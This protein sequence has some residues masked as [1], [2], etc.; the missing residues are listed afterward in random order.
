[1]NFL[2]RVVRLIDGLNERVGRFVAWLTTFLVL[3]VCFDVVTRYLLNES[4]VAV[5]ELE[6]HVF[7]VIF[8]LGAAYTLKEDGH[9]RVDVFYSHLTPKK[10]A[11]IDLVG[12]LIF[13]IPFAILVVTTSKAFVQM[14]W[15]VH[16]GSP[17]PGGLPARYLLK[18]VIPAGFVL[19][20]L[21]GIA[22]ALRSFLTLVG[23]PVDAE[24]VAAADAAGK[25]V[26]H[27]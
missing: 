15:A 10:K 23:R 19:V 16:E 17:N 6:W 8:L 11:L 5:Q 18:A 21:Q 12:C 2:I 13:L 9:V 24:D 1:M 7:A 14:S 4:M 3:V 26:D 20:L 22:L 27:A 25:E